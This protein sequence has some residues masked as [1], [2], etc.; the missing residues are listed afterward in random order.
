M[1]NVLDNAGILTQFGENAY[2][3][4]KSNF[5]SDVNTGNIEALYGELCK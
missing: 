5:L 4:A 3:Y 2:L 1:R